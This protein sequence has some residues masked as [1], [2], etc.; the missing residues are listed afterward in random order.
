MK[1]KEKR[2]TTLIEN[3][4][5]LAW[6]G[7]AH[8]SIEYGVVAFDGDRIVYVG[9][10]YEGQ[11][12]D[13]I[14]ATGRIVMPGFVNAHLHLTDTNFTKGYLEDNVGPIDRSM[15]EYSANLYRA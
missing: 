6:D 4:T 5:V 1:V 13:R 11:V 7:D 9:K 14:D 8:Y 15:K 10:H 3:G 2:M 12:D